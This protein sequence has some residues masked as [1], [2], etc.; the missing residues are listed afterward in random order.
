MQMQHR[1]DFKTQY[2]H[3]L[4]QQ[5]ITA[6]KNTLKGFVWFLLAVALVWVLTMINFFEV[7]KTLTSIAFLANIVLF[8][9]PFYIMRRGDLAKP[10]LKYF[11]L[12]MLCLVSAVIISILS[13]HAVL[14]YVFPL[15]YAVQYREKKVIWYAYAV[16]LGTI[17][18]SS[19]LSFY[20]GICDLNI[21]LQSQHVRKHYLSIITEDALHIPFNEDPMFVIIVFMIFPRAIILLVFTIMMQYNVI[22]NARDAVRIAQLTYD[23]NTDSNTNVYNKNKYQEMIDFYYPKLERVSVAFWDLND[24]KKINDRQGHAMGDRALEKLSELLTSEATDT[25]RVYR[26]GG[27]EFVTIID[28]PVPDQIYH[29][30]S[31]IAKKVKLA[32]ES[33]PYTFSVAVGYA[34]GHGKDILALVKE[35][36]VAMYENKKRC[37][38]KAKQ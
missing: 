35:A 26:I 11:L 16:N 20:Y 8:F 3:E 17:T 18:L 32:N 13:Y 4:L 31:D 14:L 15:L 5:E 7:D 23:K 12:F 36:D 22:S 21:L 24:L 2:E 19:V 37:K 9:P 25:C 27:D 28:N 6:N 30:V 1:D 29:F 34:T 33:E 10:W 38:E